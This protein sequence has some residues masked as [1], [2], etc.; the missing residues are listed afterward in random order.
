[1]T[2]TEP[3]LVGVGAIVTGA[4]RGIGQAIGRA[5]AEVDRLAGRFLHADD[6]LDGL[7]RRV[8]G[9]VGNDELVLRL[10]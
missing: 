9:I 1:M 2:M 10:A 3:G 7:L 5:L 8:D 6:D 4:G